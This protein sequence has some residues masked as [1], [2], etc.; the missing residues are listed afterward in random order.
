MKLFVGAKAV[1]VRDGKILLLR[2]S[3]EYDEG[4]EAGKWDVPGGRIDDGESVRDGLVREVKEESSLDVIPGK[5]IECFDNFPVIKGEECHIVRVYFF[6][7]EHEEKSVVL[8]QDHDQFDWVDPADIRDKVLASD[9]EKVLAA[10]K[11]LL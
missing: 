6:A 1:V 3:T 10:A 5:A 7:T 11:E 4:T 2:E 9:V 8:S